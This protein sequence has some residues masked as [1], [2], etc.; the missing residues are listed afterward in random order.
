PACVVPRR[1]LVRYASPIGKFTCRL[2]GSACLL[3][4]PGSIDPHDPAWLEYAVKVLRKLYTAYMRCGRG[5]RHLIRTALLPPVAYTWNGGKK[6]PP[7]DCLLP[8]IKLFYY[9]RGESEANGRY[10]EW[11]PGRRMRSSSRE[12]PDFNS[13]D[14]D[15]EKRKRARRAKKEEK[16][17][18]KEKE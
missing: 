17:S 7:A 15:E 11:T 2:H 4:G 16:M 3:C 9:G 18:E 8:K 14:P 5:G 12:K 13:W 1:F 10:G 6:Y